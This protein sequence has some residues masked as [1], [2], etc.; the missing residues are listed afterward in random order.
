MLGVVKRFKSVPRKLKNK[1]KKN[2]I[3]SIAKHCEDGK[4]PWSTK[5]VRIHLVRI[6]GRNHQDVKPVGNVHVSCYELIAA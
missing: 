6:G 3:A 5:E 4:A 1:L 2:I